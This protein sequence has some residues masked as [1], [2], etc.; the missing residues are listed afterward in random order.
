[1][2]YRRLTTILAIA[3]ASAAMTSAYAD[4]A[5]D[6]A[7]IMQRFQRWTAAFNAKDSAGKCELFPPDL[8]YSIPEVGQGT[9]ETICANLAKMLTSTDIQLHEHNPDVHE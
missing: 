7:A 8:V 6:E 9:P 5:A 1:M 3:F 4:A 2:F